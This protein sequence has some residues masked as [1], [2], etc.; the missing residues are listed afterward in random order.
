LPG[1]KNQ[2]TANGMPPAT[3]ALGMLKALAHLT[4]PL[5]LAGGIIAYSIGALLARYEGFIIDLP[6][7][8]AGQMAV[9]SIQ[10][11]GHYAN[12]Y[13]DV[14]YDRPNRNR[15]F[16]TGGS[17]V[18]PEGALQRRAALRA[19]LLC[20]LTALLLMAYLT[21][22][23]RIG[24]IPLILFAAGMAGTWLYSAPPLSLE[25]TGYGELSV[26]LTLSLILPL[27]S[28][29]LQAGRISMSAIFVSAPLVPMAWA[30]IA[31]FDYPDLQSDLETGKMT[32]LA[33]LGCKRTTKIIAAALFC[34][35]AL[36]IPLLL[37]GLF[38]TALLA[39]LTLPAALLTIVSLRR[40]TNGS[41][42]YGSLV[43]LA[44]VTFSATAILEALGLF[45]SA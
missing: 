16:L 31:I 8:I 42:S 24:A 36:L 2:V 15:T 29:V 44:L 17:G 39:T 1:I 21:L 25:K 18:L 20:A 45:I 11:M 19:S 9:T 41:K 5:F 33:R 40:V 37:V 6:L 23:F 13:W 22:I 4:R 43:M 28:Y 27:L 30:M 26:A 35:Y 38:T 10:L 32:F 14:E 34:S 7:Y 12:E 3:G